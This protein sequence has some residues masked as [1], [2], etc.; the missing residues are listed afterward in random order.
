M[1]NLTNQVR[2]L[3]PTSPGR[4]ATILLNYR[5][6]LSRTTPEK[7]LLKT[8]NKKAGRNHQGKITVRHRGGQVKR[9]YR[10]IDFRRNKDGVP[11]IVKSIEYD[12]NRSANICLIVYKDGEKRYILHA[13]GL[14]VGD[15]VVSGEGVDIKPGNAMPLSFVPEGSRIHN[16]ELH[17]GQGGVLARSAGGFCQL[18][19]RSE[20][21]RYMLIKTKAGEVRKVLAKCRATIGTVGNEGH[22][23]V[24]SGKAGRKRRL[25]F[26]PTVR[27][28]AMNPVDHPHGGGEGRQPIGR[29]TPVTPWGKPALG[30]KTR[31]TRKSSQKLIVRS[32]Q[33]KR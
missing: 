13:A 27:G 10:L 1:S 20:V 21:D 2:K 12:P 23:N 31:N 4:R 25:G 19:G 7:S 9:K 30:R 15:T 3:N 6:N 16:V 14:E 17:P 5:Q 29:K 24:N 22:I 26:R 33:K 18:L 11:G 32:R 8:L 28:S